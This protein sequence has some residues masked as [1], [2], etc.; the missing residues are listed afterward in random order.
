M[1]VCLF[2]GSLLQVLLHEHG[3]VLRQIFSSSRQRKQNAFLHRGQVMNLQPVCLCSTT[4]PQVGHALQFGT[5]LPLMIIV[6]ASRMAGRSTCSHLS[7]PHF[8]EE[9]GPVHSRL[10]FQQ[11]SYFRLFFFVQ[12]EQRTCRLC[13]LRRSTNDPHPGHFFIS[14]NWGDACS[15]IL[16]SKYSCSA[17]VR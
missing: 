16:V 4:R 10:Q 12:I 14:Q 5:C 6:G 9:S 2:A 17:S 3:A 7:L 15:D 1:W 11:K 8:T 13:R